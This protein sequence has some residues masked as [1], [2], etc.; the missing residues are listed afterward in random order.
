MV[1]PEY[2]ALQA[3]KDAITIVKC[4]QNE[5]TKLTS[6]EMYHK[7]LEEAK[8]MTSGNSENMTKTQK[9][10]AHKSKRMNSYITT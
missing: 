2:T 10:Q 5:E 8:N 4:I 9:K 1:Q 6:Y 7:A 3:L